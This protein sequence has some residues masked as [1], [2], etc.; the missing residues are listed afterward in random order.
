MPK[1]ISK[2]GKNKGWFKKG[3]TPWVKGKKATDKTKLKQSEA[4]LGKST[5]NKG[6]KGY[7]EGNKH[8]NWQGGISR[9]GY[10]KEFINELRILIKDRDNYTCQVCISREKL[11]VHHKDS[12]KKNNV[13]NNLITLC[14]S[15][16]MK[17]H[18]GGMKL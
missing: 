17:I 1:G 2:S 18:N 3:N 6:L 4:K 15:C 5:W 7:N 12:N 13:L 9:R 14:R 8:W 10:P 16:H 11:I